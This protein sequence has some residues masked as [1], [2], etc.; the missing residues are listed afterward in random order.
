KKEEIIETKEGILLKDKVPYLI[1]LEDSSYIPHLK[2]IIENTFPT[3][4]IDNG[5]IPFLLKGA[6]MMRPGIE[7]I[8]G[9]FKENEI[10]AIKNLNY[11][12]IIGIGKALLNSQEMNSQEKGKSIKVLHYIKDHYY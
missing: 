11:P 3:I 4:Y 6:D 12:K 5:A 2:S 7:K 9:E 1:K 8:E 10:V